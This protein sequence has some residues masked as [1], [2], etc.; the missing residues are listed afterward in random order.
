MFGL[1][2]WAMNV[3]GY[4]ILAAVIAGCGAKLVSVWDT[5]EIKGLKSTIAV[6]AAQAHATTIVQKV[7][8]KANGAAETAAQATLATQ[9]RIIIKKVPVYVSSSPKPPVGCVTNGMLRLH[10]AAV[11]GADPA[12]VQPPAGQPDAACSTLAPSDFMAVVAANYAAA[13]ANAEQLDSLESD[14]TQRVKAVADPTSADPS[15]LVAPTK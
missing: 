11:L 14:I 7:L 5:H 15:A 12:D 4:A 1:P 6:A 3:I 9:A 10:D 2:T 13:R 8:T